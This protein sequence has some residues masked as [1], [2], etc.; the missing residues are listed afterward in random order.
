MIIDAHNHPDWHGHDL[1]RYLA[2]M[3]SL[4]I[5]LCWLL[6]WECPRDEYDP[7]FIPVLPPTAGKGPLSFDRALSY[8]ERAPDRFI[9]GYAPD[10]RTPDGID[11]LK[12]AVSIYGVRIY[13]EL[14]LRMMFDNLDAIRMYRYCGEARLPVIVHIDYEYN[15]EEMY[16]RPNYWYGGG[17][18]PFERA[19]RT[20]PDTVFIGHGPGFWGHISGDDKITSTGYPE[21]RVHPGGRVSELLR[22]YPN[23]YADLSAGSGH[24]ALQ[25]DTDFAREFLLEFRDRILYAR[26]YFDNRHQELLNSLDLPEDVLAAIY[27]ENA[28]RLIPPI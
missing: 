14:K 20:C 26:D 27:A 5:E 9:L 7:R 11:R 15:K 22:K 12:S 18:E 4:G 16:P 2:N 23:L 19:V 28:R 1:E 17:I 13:G 25:R 10:P 6:T 24:N 21:G 8:K 3:D